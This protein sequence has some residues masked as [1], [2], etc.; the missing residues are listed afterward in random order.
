MLFHTFCHLP[1]IG[2]KTE[3]KIWSEGIR[4]WDDALS[5][6]TF[7]KILPRGLFE[8]SYSF[9]LRSLEKMEKK[10]LRFFNERLHNFNRWRLFSHFREEAVYLDIET[11]GLFPPDDY[12]TLI[13]LFDGTKIKTY[14][15]NI[16]LF[17]FP[18]DIMKHHIIITYNGKCFDIPFIERYFGIR[19][20]QIHFD[21]RFMLKSL[22]LSGGLK[23]CE[24]MIGINRGELQGIDGYMAVLLWQKYQEGWTEALETLIAY[25]VEDTVNLEKLMVFFYNQKM[26]QFAFPELALP[27]PRKKIIMSSHIHREILDEIKYERLRSFQNKEW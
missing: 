12:I 15:H 9:L 20:P 23:A 6:P 14:I 22:G 11:S 7:Q 21:L 26:Y 18:R 13:T 17:D 4:N 27:E 8:T 25:N 16:N 19:L 3:K 24:K 2:E 5:A 1:H 10:D